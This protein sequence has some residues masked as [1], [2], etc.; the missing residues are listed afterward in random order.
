MIHK[1][2]LLSVATNE[3]FDHQKS[4]FTGENAEKEENDRSKMNILEP[5][6]AGVENCTLPKSWPTRPL[7][8]IIG[9]MRLMIHNPMR[10][11][12]WEKSKDIYRCAKVVGNSKTSLRTLLGR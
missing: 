1:V 8:G 2:L 7:L 5:L 10:M 11:M 12:E 3:L 6:D 4:Q 9:P